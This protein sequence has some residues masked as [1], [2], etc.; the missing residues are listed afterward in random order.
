MRIAPRPPGV[1]ARGEREV[2]ARFTIRRPRLWQPGRPRLYSLT[3]SAGLRGRRLSSYRL[4]FGIRHWARSRGGGFLL[5]GRR[6]NVR[7]ASLHEEHPVTGG[8]LTPGQRATLVSR[9]RQAGATITRAHYPLHPALLEAFDRNGILYWSQAPIY[10]VPNSFL[11]SPSFRAVALDLNRSTVLHNANHASVFVWSIG[12]ELAGSRGENGRIGSGFATFIRQ[13]EREVKRLDPTRPV[14]I[15]RQSRIGEPIFNRALAQLD[16]LGVNEYFGW[17]DSYA[18]SRP[19]EPARTDELGPYL[20]QVHKAYPRTPLFVTEFGAEGTRSGPVQQK[21]SL[22]FQTAFM[23]QHHA[24]HASKRYI[25]GS[26]AWAL[27][28]FRV[29]PGW[30]GGAPREWA[31]PPWHNKSLIDESGK[32][33]P[34]Y[35]VMQRLW[36]R[37][38]QLR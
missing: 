16:V 26:I 2:A 1:A 35:G 31:T 19:R 7:G 18:L 37:T 38:R 20:D 14:G 3:V 10:Q 27:R 13:A 22:E 21:G 5:N 24:I 30:T 8:A 36:R 11:D 28:D 9:L 17:Y 33:K 25:N 34:V 23:R 32:A 4:S 12:N 29:E 15:D 6:L